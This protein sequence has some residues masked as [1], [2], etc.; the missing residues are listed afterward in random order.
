[1]STHDHTAARIRVL[2]VDDHR[3]VREG[4]VLIIGRQ[5]DMEVV[6]TVSSAQDAIASFKELRPDVTL[7]DLQ[8]GEISGLDAI[9]AIKAI[10][11]AARIVVLTMY[12]GDED[13]YRALQAGATTYLLKDTLSDDLVRVVRQIHLG[14]HPAMPEVEA[15][16]AER[17]AGPT[18]T[19][20]EV[21]VMELLKESL[22]NREIATALGISEETVHVHVRNILTKLKVKD[23]SGAITVALRRGII[24]LH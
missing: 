4:L 14:E 3:I 20:R 6:G 16:L 15:R 7:M 13:I 21:Q 18:L 12:Q 22:R 23:R 11:P 24:H 2:C 5:P 8:L 9:R 1:M 17:A 19:P 10:E